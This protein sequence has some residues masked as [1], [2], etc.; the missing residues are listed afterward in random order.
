MSTTEGELD[1]E[2]SHEREEG[3]VRTF[4]LRIL[5]ASKSAST[6]LSFTFLNSL[7]F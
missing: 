4:V 5:F 1:V 6:F 3:E 7:F 2:V